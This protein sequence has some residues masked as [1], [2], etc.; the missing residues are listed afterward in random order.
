MSVE[1]TC[2]VSAERWDERRVNMLE[3]IL[4]MS[5]TVVPCPVIPLTQ[6]VSGVVVSHSLEDDLEMSDSSI[7]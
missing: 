6:V 2:V 5:L 4:I 1:L 7:K 3:V